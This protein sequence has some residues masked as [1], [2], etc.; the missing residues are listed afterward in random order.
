MRHLAFVSLITVA[1]SSA[2]ALAASPEPQPSSPLR[3]QFYI[4][5]GSSFEA[6]PRAPSL[7]LMNPRAAARFDRLLS[8]KKDLLVGLGP[9]LKER[10]L[11]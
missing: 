1:S 7:A 9:S 11:K 8:L 4:F 2:P 3:S 10:A 6:G 5:D